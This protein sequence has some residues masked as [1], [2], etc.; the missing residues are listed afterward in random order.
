MSACIHFEKAAFIDLFAEMFEVKTSEQNLFKFFESKHV[1]IFSGTFLSCLLV[2]WF[3]KKA[4]LLLK[5]LK[6]CT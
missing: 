3:W 4:L 1:F 2:C 6:F 5:V